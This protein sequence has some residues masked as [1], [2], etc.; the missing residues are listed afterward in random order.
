[1]HGIDQLTFQLGGNMQP[2]KERM[3]PVTQICAHRGASGHAPENTMAAFKTAL[4]M[5]ADWLEFDVQLSK[6]EHVVVFHD[7]TLERTTNLNLQQ[8]ISD[9]TLSQLKDLDA[10]NWFHSRFKGEKIPTL[11]EV[12]KE[13]KG[14]IGLNIE[15]KGI[16]N[17]PSTGILE[18]KVAE[19]LQKFDLFCSDQVLIS[20][21]DA[22]MLTKFHSYSPETPIGYLYEPDEH[23]GCSNAPLKSASEMHAKAIHP[24][25]SLIDKLFVENANKLG[26]QIN[27]W[28]VNN[29]ADMQKLLHIPVN[30]IITNYPDRLFKLLR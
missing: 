18:Q 11:E 8:R 10:G 2:S 21:F 24:H 23:E 29:P 25:F 9:M 3:E 1:M 26:L 28:T 15:L 30:M 16:H 6:D 5:G 20:S 27:T 17:T 13:F 14:E 7:E 22:Y 12:L 19:L 4:A